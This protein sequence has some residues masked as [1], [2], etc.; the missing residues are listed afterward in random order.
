ML[1]NPNEGTSYPYPKGTDPKSYLTVADFALMDT[2][3]DGILDYKDDP[4][5]PWYPGDDAVDCKCCACMLYE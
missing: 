1:W 3:K 5:S 2:N 4:Y